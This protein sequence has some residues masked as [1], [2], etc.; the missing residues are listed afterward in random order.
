M[1]EVCVVSL[2]QPGHWIIQQKPAVCV[3]S[4]LQILQTR[5]QKHSRT[6]IHLSSKQGEVD[7]AMLLSSSCIN[8]AHI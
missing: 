4:D 3:M 6:K 8:T 1:D 2:T 5:S 7:K